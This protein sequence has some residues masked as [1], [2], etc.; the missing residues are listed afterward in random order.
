LSTVQNIKRIIVI[1][2]GRITEEGSHEELIRKN[3]LYTNL[4]K[5]NLIKV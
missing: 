3:G 5:R 4:V 2:E 1:D